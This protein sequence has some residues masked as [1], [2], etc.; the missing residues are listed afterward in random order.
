MTPPSGRVNLLVCDTPQAVAERAASLIERQVRAKPDS[1][2]LVATGNTPM[3]TYAELARRK[4]KMSEVCAIQ[5]DEYLGVSEH[6][7]RSLYG[8]MERSFTRP[9]GVGRV[10]RFDAMSARPDAACAEHA[11]GIRTLGGIDLAILGL[12]PNGHLGFNEPPSDASAPTRPVVLS[13]ASLLSNAPYW[14]PLAVPRQALTV[15]MDLILAARACLLIVTGEHKREVLGRM[16][17]GP[18]TPQLPA[19]YLQ[20][21]PLTVVADRAAC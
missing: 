3:P 15:G 18:R 9:L 7:P 2:L 16:L 19:S 1:S 8:W 11:A 10:L 13:A 17:E 6:D 5:L 20:D 14:A 4:P 12:G 21:A